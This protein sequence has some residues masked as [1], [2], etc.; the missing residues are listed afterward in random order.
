MRLRA[1]KSWIG[2]AMIAVLAV[3]VCGWTAPTAR[4]SCGDYV[5]SGPAS[6]SHDSSHS[7]PVWRHAVGDLS[8][9][10]PDARPEGRAVCPCTRRPAEEPPCQGP[11]CSGS[12]KPMS[13]PTTAPERPNERWA[14]SDSAPS[15][16]ASEP[17]AHILFDDGSH[18]IHQVML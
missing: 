10:E 5:S 9:R 1:P 17:M 13:V 7:E 15:D 18:R 16:S 2:S 14:V 11:W 8:P 6:A 3:V 12:H 4:G